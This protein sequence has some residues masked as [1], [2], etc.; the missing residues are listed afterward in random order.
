M[1]MTVGG[2]G[3]STQAYGQVDP[4]GSRYLLGDHAGNLLLLVRPSTFPRA[5][6]SFCDAI[7]RYARLRSE[8]A[9]EECG[10]RRTEAAFAHRAL[11]RVLRRCAQVLMHD[12]TGVVGLKLEALGAHL[13]AE[14]AHVPRQRRRLRGLL[15]RRLAG[16]LLVHLG[17][18]SVGFGGLC[19]R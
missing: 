16:A 2:R 3:L 11:R 13:R 19:A 5:H 12:G 9:F 6:L 7:A 10:H 8:P 14:H 1:G 4:D 17:T 15:L 18:G